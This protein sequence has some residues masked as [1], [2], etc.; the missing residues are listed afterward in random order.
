VTFTST[1]N[2]SDASGPALSKYYSSTD[3]GVYYLYQ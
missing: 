3:K 2:E 1:T